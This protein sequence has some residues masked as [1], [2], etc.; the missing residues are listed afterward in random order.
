[1]GKSQKPR[2]PMRKAWNQGGVMI[3]TQPWKINTAFGPIEGIID[4]LERDGTNDE[5]NGIAVV[6][7][8]SDGAWC[9]APVAII[10]M[11]EAFEIHERRTGRILGMGPLRLIAQRLEDG[12]DIYDDETAA[13]R[14]AINRMKAETMQMTAEYGAELIRAFLTMEAMQK[15]AA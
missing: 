5:I 2:K 6:K 1:M 8:L 14:A 10:G 13:A 4:Q 15:L 7:D 9:N 12:A 11:I 3:R